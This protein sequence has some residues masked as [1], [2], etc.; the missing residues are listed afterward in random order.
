MDDSNKLGELKNPSV[1][2]GEFPYTP[3][4]KGRHKKGAKGNAPW[5]KTRKRFRT[6]L[7]RGY[8]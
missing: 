7:F 5:L 8:R 1:V 6:P 3:K 4:P 2:H